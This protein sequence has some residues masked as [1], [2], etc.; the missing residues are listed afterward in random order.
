MSD[1][2]I[3]TKTGCPYCQKAVEDYRA[4]GIIFKEVNISVDTAAK[5]MVKE[6]LGARKVPVIVEDGKLTS[7]GY[8]GGG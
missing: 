8:N 6:K 7:T 2:V 4:K 5:Q 1:V 3:Y